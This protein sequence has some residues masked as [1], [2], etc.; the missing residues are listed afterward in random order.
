MMHKSYVRVLW[1]ED[2]PCPRSRAEG[3]EQHAQR[4]LP[5]ACVFDV[6]FD[7]MESLQILT[8]SHY[9]A[10]FL[11]RSVR[12]FEFDP[13]GDC[14][15]RARCGSNVVNIIHDM[16][17]LCP[18]FIVV[19]DEGGGDQSSVEGLVREAGAGVHVMYKSDVLKSYPD[20]LARICTSCD[21]RQL[22]PPGL[23]EAQI[24]RGPG[25][26][27]GGSTQGAQAAPLPAHTATDVG[28]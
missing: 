24:L 26:H 19:D 13:V 12:G 9:D 17:I 21:Q 14:Q 1:A 4:F 5:M 20:L 22:P 11:F 6:S 2:V 18:I 28:A 27:R 10:I 8:R 7:A 23:V 25:V 15:S 3:L 16:Q